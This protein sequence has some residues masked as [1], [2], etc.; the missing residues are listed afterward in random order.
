MD[1]D[2]IVVGTDGVVILVVLGVVIIVDEDVV[3]GTLVVVMIVVFGAGA[4]IVVI[5]VLVLVITVVL[6]ELFEST[7]DF[8]VTVVWPFVVLLLEESGGFT[9]EFSALALDV[10]WVVTAACGKL[11]TEGVGVETEICLYK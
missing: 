8:W 6:V 7:A 1:L 3:V 11:V 4:V 10:A 5:G 2:G 9:V